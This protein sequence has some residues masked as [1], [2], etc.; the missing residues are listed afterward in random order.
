MERHFDC[1]AC[2]KCCQGWLPLS[3]D[4]AL[5][6]A[7]RFPLF[8]MWSPVRQGGKSFDLTQKLGVTVALKK[9]KQAAVRITP[10]S[11]VPHHTPCPALQPDGLCAVHANKPQRCKTMPLSGAR[12]EDD[13]ADLLIP[14]AGWDCDTS[15]A[16]PVVYRDKSVVA[17]DAFEAERAIL[18]KDSQVL[19]PFGEFM[20]QGAPQVRQDVEKMAL[21]PQ[22]GHVVMSFSKLLPRLPQVDIYAFAAQQLPVMDAFAELTSGNADQAKDHQRYAASAIEWRQILDNR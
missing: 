1:T 19:K 9:R 2:G 4:D 18:L 12:A 10:F 15:D 20:L 13:Q 22:G 7:E 3:I 21:R 11:Y 14:K 8:L 5:N 17:R 6:H 16:A